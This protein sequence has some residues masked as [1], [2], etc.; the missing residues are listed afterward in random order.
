MYQRN[1]H[2]T[3]HPLCRCDLKWS[4]L[5]KFSHLLVAKTL[6]PSLGVQKKIKHILM[7]RWMPW[8]LKRILHLKQNRKKWKKNYWKLFRILNFTSWTLSSRPQKFSSLGQNPKKIRLF[9]ILNHVFVGV[10]QYDSE[11]P[12]H[13]LELKKKLIFFWFW[14][15]KNKFLW[16]GTQGPRGKIQS[17]E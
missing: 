5:V 6:P 8:V 15:K 2:C 12:K 16:Y 11:T 10:F 14:L 4:A 7:L 13:A 1:F 9:T 3:P 17:F